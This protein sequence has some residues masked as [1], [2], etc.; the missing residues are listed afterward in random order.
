MIAQTG[1]AHN[2]AVMKKIFF[3]YILL[4]VSFA[5]HATET[6]TV[7]AKQV[8]LNFLK[9]R[10]PVKQQPS[11]TIDQIVTDSLGRKLLYIMK[12]RKGKGF[13]ITGA[14]DV[15][16]P[17]LAYSQESNFEDLRS[18][19]PAFVWWYKNMI[20]QAAEAINPG[21]NSQQTPEKGWIKYSKPVP[22]PKG[23]KDVGPLL[24]TRWNQGRYYNTLC[25]VT[26]TGGSD[27]HVWVGCVA[28]AMAQVMKYWNYPDY[29]SG[30]RSYEHY[31]YGT[32]SADFEATHYDWT[33]MPD[34]LSNYNN[35]VATL[36]YH[37]G[38]SIHMN[39]GPD[40]SSAYTGS[41]AYALKKYFD[42]AKDI[43]AVSRYV[44]APEVWD[45]LLRAQLDL[46]Q[47][48]PYSGGNHAFNVDGYQ[49]TDYFH[50]NWGWGGSYNGYFYMNDLT[51]GSHTFTSGQQAI[52]NVRPDCGEA[53][54][55]TDTVTNV[56][57][58]LFDNGGE[59]SNYY[60]CSDSKVLLAPH[61]ASN[62]FLEFTRFDIADGDTLFIYDGQDTTGTIIGSLTGDTLPGN[63]LTPG[64]AVLLRFISGSY[65]SHAGYTIDYTSAFKDAGI[66]DILQPQDKTCGIASDSIIIVIR[67]SGID[68]LSDIPVKIKISGPA[69]MDS[70]SVT[71]PGPLAR[72]IDT[73]LVGNLST[74]LPGEYKITAYTAQPG[75][76]LINENDSTEKTF[77]IK[78]PQDI[79]FFENVDN[80]KWDRGDWKDLNQNTWINGDYQGEN[81]EGGNRYFTSRIGTSRNAFFI[82]DR[83]IRGVSTFTTLSFDYRILNTMKWPPVADTLTPK[84][85]VYVIIST[86]CGNDYDTIFTIDHTNHLPDT[87]FRRI[88]LSLDWFA[89]QEIIFGF[90]TEW[91]SAYSEID[92]DN[93]LVADLPHN[94]IITGGAACEGE[95]L[96]LSGSMVQGGVG[97][98]TY[99][100]QESRDGITWTNTAGESFNLYYT[101]TA[102]VS[103]YYRRIIAD[104]LFPPD[105]SNILFI[106]T[107]PYPTVHVSADTTICYGESTPLM[108]TGGEQ[109]LW[110]TGDT[111]SVISVTP[112]RN[113]RYHV[114][115]TNGGICSR[116]DSVFITVH[117]LPEIN[118]G[119]DTLLCEGDSI[120]LDA[121]IFDTYHWNTGSN[122]SAI[123]VKNTGTYRITVTNSHGCETSDSVYIQVSV[124]SGKEELQ[125]F[126]HVWPNPVISELTIEGLDGFSSGIPLQIIDM[127][128]RTVWNGRNDRN[129]LR[130]QTRW[131]HR[132]IYLLLI[133]GKNAVRKIK[134]IKY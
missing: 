127:Q 93:L 37:C 52:L 85:K 34:A 106:K 60:N 105:T 80:L 95:K 59:I 40:G 30:S 102:R 17:V 27:G 13:V 101:D 29:G 78:L 86:D 51:P 130:I 4:I 28:V 15:I 107:I 116:E 48:M 42:Y 39:Y 110:N 47:P 121:G 3:L 114:R 38:V 118:L 44:I 72:N 46:G 103:S 53:P 64:G 69:G 33:S 7:F 133:E 82:Y 112:D 20:T 99:L 22:V 55:V 45:S 35:A 62:I 104:T 117:P 92:L 97:P 21:K 73:F 90:T 65:T 70:M 18:G 24:S 11:L 87:L 84:E 9:E 115:V 25:P 91:D 74:L 79:P 81:E 126:L 58:T 76:T 124:C 14:N 83:K 129:T 61:G 12:I 43:Q 98:V 1:F 6:D 63:I 49:G 56:T 108:A 123:Y 109:Y 119:S 96:T 67:N 132:G 57:G 111:T 94:N 134:I 88:T 54:A 66:T 50:I 75:D 125:Q 23:I 5:G 131:W 41:I 89:G 113:T 122:D 128:G 10:F 26:S 8:A 77:R 19:P 120:L 2:S 68:T 36:M 100:W 16:K 32:Q 71:F 31:V